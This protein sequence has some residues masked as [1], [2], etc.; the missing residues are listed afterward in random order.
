MGVFY[1]FFK[2][3]QS[4]ILPSMVFC[5]SLNVSEVYGQTE[6]SLEQA[7]DSALAN[8]YKIARYQEKLSE[9][10]KLRKAAVGNYFPS[11]NVSAGYTYLSD[12]PLIN[13]GLVKESVDQ[14]AGKYGADIARALGLSDEPA[15]VLEELITSS[16]GKLP[17]YD[18]KIDQNKYP[19]LN[20]NVLQP[21]FT[22]GKITAGKRYAEANEHLASIELDMVKD[23]II[24]EVVERYLSVALLKQVVKTRK[25]VLAGMKKHERQAKRAIEIGVIPPHQILRAKVAVADAERDLSDDQ[26][27]LSLARLALKTSL[28]M[29]P[30][31]TIKITDE[32]KFHPCEL[33]LDEL[34]N[35]ARNGNPVFKV[36]EQKKV[37]VKQKQ[38]LDRSA[39]WPNIGAFGTYNFFREEYPVI[40]PR[41]VLGIQMNLNLFHGFKTYN[42]VQ[43]SG[44][45]AK[46]VEKVDIYAQKQIELL[47]NKA[48]RDVLNYRIRY[49]KYEP[50]VNLARKNLEINEKRFGEGLAKSTDV[51]DARLMYEGAQVERLYTLYQYYKALSS[52]FIATGQ[53]KRIISVIEGI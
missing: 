1:W 7:V 12:D 36:I 35:D 18:I 10:Q 14:V 37:Q 8:N 9:K 3:G 51:I 25:E 19:N 50:T 46:E 42:E 17:A 4:L 15:H 40:P 33:N 39:F 6:Y 23:E 21:I 45:L 31:N 28:G 32:L 47:V 27:K 49:E 2:K 30:G 43:A 44:H 38:A 34:V 22:G 26:N 41:F 24:K 53:P 52:L 13:M 11:V 5:F 20:I 16:L 48:Y 29:S